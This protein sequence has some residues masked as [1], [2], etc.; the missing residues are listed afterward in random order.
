MISEYVSP[1][2]Q[3]RLYSLYR[4]TDEYFASFPANASEIH[5]LRLE[6]RTPPI[7]VPENSFGKFGA[8]ENPGHRGVFHF[9]KR[10]I[11]FCF[12]DGDCWDGTQF[13]H[14]SSFLVLD[15]DH[16]G[17]RSRAIIE[18]KFRDFDFL[19]YDTGGGLDRYHFIIPHNLISNAKIDLCYHAFMCEA[20][21]RLDNTV[22]NPT[23]CISMPGNSHRITG[24]RKTL[25]RANSGRRLRFETVT[26][27]AMLQD[28][29][30][31]FLG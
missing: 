12:D 9:D 25:I 16:D 4:P 10:H 11:D 17:A 6:H 31:I 30:K 28:G 7:F 13:P 18:E 29:K 24:V 19:L 20:R 26:P 1:E 5:T 15:I 14:Y 8:L 27:D 22:W 2:I 3:K 23:S 21:I